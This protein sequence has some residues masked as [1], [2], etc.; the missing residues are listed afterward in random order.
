MSATLADQ[1]AAGSSSAERTRDPSSFKVTFSLLQPTERVPAMVDRRMPQ[2][3]PSDWPADKAKPSTTT[4][5]L[6]QVGH[7]FSQDHALAA[8]VEEKC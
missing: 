8:P 3:R 7:H 1:K 5:L 6:G 4:A 2:W